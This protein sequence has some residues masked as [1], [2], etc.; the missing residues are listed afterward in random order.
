MQN[1][2]ESIYLLTLRV[3]YLEQQ[4]A[5]IVDAVLIIRGLVIHVAYSVMYMIKI[6][7]HVALGG[8]AL[9]DVNQP[10]VDTTMKDKTI[11]YLAVLILGH[12][13]IL[14]LNAYWLKIDNVIFSFLRESLTIPFLLLQ[15]VLLFISLY[16][17]LIKRNRS[18]QINTALFI[19]LIVSIITFGS[20]FGFIELD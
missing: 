11:L 18:W 14:F 4:V 19:L 16:Q 15:P 9:A 5:V 1:R 6:V 10:L 20:L 8:I 12:F 7:K 17:V 3:I 2:L 13:A